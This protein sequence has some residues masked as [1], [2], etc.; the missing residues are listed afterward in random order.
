MNRTERRAFIRMAK[1]IKGLQTKHTK[2]AFGR[3]PQHIMVLRDIRIKKLIEK[4]LRKELNNN[5]K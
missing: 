5:E 1:S 3:P 2:G 4:S